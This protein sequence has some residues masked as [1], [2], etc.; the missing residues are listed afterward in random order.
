MADANRIHLR[1]RDIGNSLE[2]KANLKR[3][4]TSRQHSLVQQL[5]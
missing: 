4:L 5:G 2:S 1:K 3:T